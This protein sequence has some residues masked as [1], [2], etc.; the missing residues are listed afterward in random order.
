MNQYFRC[1]SK[2]LRVGLSLS[3]L[4]ATRK[5]FSFSILFILLLFTVSA[6]NLYFMHQQCYGT[7]NE[8]QID[9]LAFGENNSYYLGITITQADSAFENYH[10]MNDIAIIKTDSNGNVL[11]R[12]CYGGSNNET[13]SKIINIDD[14]TFYLV[15]HTASN[16]GDVKEN[17]YDGDNTWVVK[18]DNNGNI[19][20][21]KCIGGEG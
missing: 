13:V 6:Q 9:C 15:G 19:I 11:W 16:N 2:N 1:Q 18:I 17:G 14:T 3:F 8:D 5:K 20:W 12:K 4:S 21:E 10:G 7:E